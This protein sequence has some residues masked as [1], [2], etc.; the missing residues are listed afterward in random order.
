MSEMW[1]GLSCFD[2]ALS[3]P[4]QT[5]RKTDRLNARSFGAEPW[6]YRPV[7][8][9]ARLFGPSVADR[10]RSYGNRGTCGWHGQGSGDARRARL[11]AERGR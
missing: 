11:T 5:K 8:L 3:F 2:K 6:L 4:R 7:S 9:A 10:P 1:Q